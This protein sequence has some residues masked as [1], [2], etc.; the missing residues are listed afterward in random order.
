MPATKEQTDEHPIIF[1]SWSICRILA[2]EKTQTRR[3]VKPQP[4][5]EL[6][7]ALDRTPRYC[8]ETTTGYLKNGPG[9][10]WMAQTAIDEGKWR[11]VGGSAGCPYGQPSDVL[12]VRE[13]FRLPHDDLTP[14]E[15]AYETPQEDFVVYYEAD[16]TINGASAGGGVLDDG[17]GGW[18][19][20]KD[21]FGRKRPPIHMPKEL[22]RLC[23]RLRVE[24]VRVERVQEITP[25]EVIAEGIYED[26]LRQMYS[27]RGRSLSGAKTGISGESISAAMWKRG[28]KW[29]WSDIHGDGA[30]G[31]NPWVWVVTFSRT[32]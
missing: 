21:R 8:D 20:V 19:T 18:S 10:Y 25:Q 4:P 13:A 23:L 22:C 9:W 28:F 11:P 3:I 16:D 32:E 1:N 29:L 24:D 26:E 15:Y 14:K 5:H 17:D 30:W 2:G 31:E 12:W 27:E 6:G 7:N